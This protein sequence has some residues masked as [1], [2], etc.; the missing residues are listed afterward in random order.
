MKGGGMGHGTGG[1]G[2]SIVEYL[3]IV[4]AIVAVIVTAIVPQIRNRSQTLMQN[5]INTM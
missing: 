4:A 2:Q 1:K 5:A 3:V